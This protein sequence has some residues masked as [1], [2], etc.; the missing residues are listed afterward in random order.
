MAYT[1]LTTAGSIEAYYSNITFSTGT[2]PTL[3]SVGAWI[4]E[5]TAIVYGAI[6][7]M[8][9]LPIVDTDDLKFLKGLSDQYVVANVNFVLGKNTISATNGQ[10]LQPRTVSHKEFYDTLKKLQ[11]GEILLMNSAGSTSHVSSRSFLA[12]STGVIFS[13]SRDEALW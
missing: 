8:Y 4:D 13:S 9:T 1:A 6:G 7:S 3:A 5:A 11:G 10:V 12:T 2:K